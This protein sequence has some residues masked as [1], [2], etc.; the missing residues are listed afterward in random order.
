MPK[1]KVVQIALGKEDGSL[2]GEYLDDKG[3]IWYQQ[4]LYNKAKDFRNK[5]FSHY[6]WKQ[7]ELPDE[8][9]DE[10]QA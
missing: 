3:R 9:E 7:L 1:I 5:T 8:P 10:E 6:E 4:A 2:Y